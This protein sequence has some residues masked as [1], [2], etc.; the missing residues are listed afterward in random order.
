MSA[1]FTSRSAAT[2]AFL[3]GWAC[4]DESRQPLVPQIIA[5][6][7]E[8]AAVTL[9]VVDKNG[10]SV[11]AHS[12]AKVDDML[13]G[14]ENDGLRFE[15]HLGGNL[16]L[17]IGGATLPGTEPLAA[18]QMELFRHLASLIQGVLSCILV[19][20]H[21]RQLIGSPFDRLSDLEWEV[22]RALEGQ[23]KEEKIAMT[24]QCTHNTLH[25]HVRR[26]FK[27]LE[28]KGRKE[29][30]AL[31]F[32]ARQRVQQRALKRIGRRDRSGETAE[33]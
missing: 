22:C 5:D 18:R 7:V 13:R 30:V 16:T 26:I 29:L 11:L 24:L 10:N 32:T 15:A 17:R 19:Q 21:D 28:V 27:K 3:C 20:Q 9:E 8:L 6:K 33:A 23:E 25:C 2:A 31:L 1:E 4:S 14:S 12:H